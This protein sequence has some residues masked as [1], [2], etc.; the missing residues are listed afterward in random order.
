MEPHFFQKFV[1]GQSYSAVFVGLEPPGDVNFV[2]ISRQLIGWQALHAPEFA[3][4]GSVGPA[5]LD[6]PTEHMIRRIGNVLM[7]KFELRGIFGC[8]FVIASD[9]TP[10]LIEV[11]PR[12]PASAELFELGCGFTLLRS[13][14]AAF[15]VQW[16]NPDA[17]FDTYPESTL[18]KGVLFAPEDL[19]MPAMDSLQIATPY[20]SV[21][22]I[23]DVSPPGTLIKAGQ[24][25][26]TFI[27]DG[28]DDDAATNRLAQ[29]AREF[30]NSALPK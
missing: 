10:W 7:W 23:A 25:V 9:G 20:Q 22:R 29:A 18:A 5:A 17:E 15:G 21:N 6:V 30:L 4:C 2:G 19:T 24:P 8:D 11:N 3:W 27:L 16:N 13:H 28:A 12:Y 26:C 14:A 1:S